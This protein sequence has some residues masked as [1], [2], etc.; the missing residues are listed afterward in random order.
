M[1]N[2]RYSSKV[3]GKGGGIESSSGAG[4]TKETTS[5]TN[6]NLGDE[7]KEK[8]G[9]CGKVV[10]EGDTAPQCEICDIWYHTACI[11]MS[12][13]TY[14]ILQ[15]ESIHWFCKSYDG[16]LK[17]MMKSFTKLEGRQD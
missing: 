8:C 11:S 13:D 6:S 3:G 9:C 10:R 14:N 5:Q 12:I 4:A 2:R 17:K 16:R 7:V 1:P 15:Q